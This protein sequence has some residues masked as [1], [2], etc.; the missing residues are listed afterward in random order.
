MRSCLASGFFQAP[1]S[2]EVT[3]SDGARIGE[4]NRLNAEFLTSLTALTLELATLSRRSGKNGF[5]AVKQHDDKFV[6]AAAG[7]RFERDVIIGY[8]AN[9]TFI[10]AARNG[11]E[12]DGLIAI[13]N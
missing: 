6:F 3:P 7:V 10:D 13:A 5:D 11:L 1:A 12:A 9:R 8:I 2:F 4:Q